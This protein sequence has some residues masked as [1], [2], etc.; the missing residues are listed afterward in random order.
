MDLTHT[1]YLLQQYQTGSATDA[2]WEELAALLTNAANDETIKEALQQAMEQHIPGTA[3]QQR[4][5]QALLQKITSID[6]TPVQQPAV[7]RTT[8]ISKWGWLAAAAV[9]LLLIGGTYI[10]FNTKPAPPVAVI[11]EKEILPGQQGA[12]LTL[13]N[14]KTI[15][16]DSLNNGTIAQQGQTAVVLTNGMIKYHEGAPASNGEAIAY[17]TLSTPRGRQYQLTLP[18]GTK[19]WL[20]AESAITYPV[21]FTGNNRQVR[22]SGEVYFEV[23]TLRLRSG[24]KMPFLVDVAGKANIEVLGTHFNVNAYADEADIRTTL[25]EGSVKASA[26]PDK[27][28]PAGNPQSAILKPGE[29]ISISQTSPAR[30]DGRSGG[31]LSHPIPVQTDEVMAWKNGLFVLQGANLEEVIRQLAR[32]YDIDIRYE[33]AVPAFQFEGKMDRGVKLPTVI[34]WFT[35]LGIPCHLENRTLVIGK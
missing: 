18:D 32:W 6:Q 10:W 8:Y 24:L 35:D 2:E 23:A 19:V 21:A 14:G 20:N 22:T 28:G 27:S 13:A 25:L 7:R 34:K 15:V 11:A 17:N 12:V 5:Y 29:Q 1:A 33:S 9:L 31:Q 16:L 30:P 3:F 4:D 26:I